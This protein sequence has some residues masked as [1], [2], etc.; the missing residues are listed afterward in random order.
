MNKNNSIID[1][2]ILQQ[3]SLSLEFKT[4]LNMDSIA[5]TSTAFLN[6]N[7]GSI[8]VGVSDARDVVGIEKDIELAAEELRKYLLEN[9]TPQPPLS[10]DV[11]DYRSKSVLLVSVWN[12]ATPPYSYKHVIYSR[13]GQ[14]TSR[15]D[16]NSVSQLINKREQADYNWERMPLMGTDMDDINF[17]E[18]RKSMTEAIVINPQRQFDDEEDFLVKS[19]LISQGSPTQAAIILFANNPTRFMPQA[20]IRLT[21]YNKEKELVEERIFDRNLFANIEDILALLDA[22]YGVTTKIDG[23]FRQVKK[24]YPEVA[25]REGIINACVHRDYSNMTGFLQIRVFAD[26]TEISNY[27]GLANGMTVTELKR[28]KLASFLR[29]PDI[30]Y[31]CYVRKYME[32]AGS[33]IARIL[34]NCKTNGF[35]TPKWTEKNNILTLSFPGVGVKTNNSEGINEGINEEINEGINEGINVSIDGVSQ[36]V[37]REL[38][39][40]L[41]YIDANGHVKVSDLASFT[42]KSIATI[43]RYVKLLRQHGYIEF[44]GSK[45]AGGY[46]LTINENN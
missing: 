12:G 4:T 26:K 18:V 40:V 20:R 39:R 44:V 25:I 21:F 9:I 37:T 5:K 2:L 30:A 35:K 19:G 7:G 24:N 28:G 45:K 27:G 13:K 34:S 31:I 8:L 41:K 3:E 10:V 36:D 46:R 23:V 6:T 22:K 14:I 33:G 32:M 17:E 29:N 15:A 43:E 38:G 42:G 1:N 16:S 11:F